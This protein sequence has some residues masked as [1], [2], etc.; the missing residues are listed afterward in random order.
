MR[1]IVDL[2]GIKVGFGKRVP[3]IAEIGVNH[4]GSLSRAKNMVDLANE[5][6]ADF[7]KFQTYVAKE[8]MI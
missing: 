8:D 2:D 7:I 4:L 5:G 1:K 6:G 3:I